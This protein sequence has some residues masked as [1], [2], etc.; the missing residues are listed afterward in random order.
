MEFLR[1]LKFVFIFICIDNKTDVLNDNEICGRGRSFGPMS[2]ENSS[3][4]VIEFVSKASRRM[5]SSKKGFRLQYLSATEQSKKM[6]KLLDFLLK[7][8]KYFM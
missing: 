6:V 8:T 2:F 7:I 4:L 1:I 3:A 5:V